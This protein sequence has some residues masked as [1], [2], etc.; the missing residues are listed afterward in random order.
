MSRVLCL[1]RQRNKLF[2]LKNTTPHCIVLYSLQCAFTNASSVGLPNIA[3]NLA[4]NVG[5]FPTLQ[6]RKITLEVTKLVRGRAT[7]RRPQVA[8]AILIQKV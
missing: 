7:I 5:I 2:L 3:V 8:S 6:M 4:R 1:L